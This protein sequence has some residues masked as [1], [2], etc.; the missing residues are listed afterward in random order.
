M[1]PA[2]LIARARS[3][4]GRKTKYL[5]GGGGARPTTPT[6]GVTCDCSGFVCWALGLA[7]KTD[8]PLYVRL[9]GGWVNT[10]AMVADAFTEVGMFY[11]LEQ[12]QVGAVI[13]YP[14][15]KSGGGPRVG[16]CG[17]ITEA[18]AGFATKVIH[19]S[20]GNFRNFGDAIAE[21]G[22]KAFDRQASTIYAW[23]AGIENIGD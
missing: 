23:Y 17:I 18:P 3:A 6:P 20:S 7:R 11:L 9:N 19:C 5:L 8:N 13:V 12:P 4:A 10:D 16:H 22:L 2:D 1:T 14:S 21:T 15:A